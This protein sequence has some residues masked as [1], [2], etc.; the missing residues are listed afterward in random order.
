MKYTL[1]ITDATADEICA[2][3]GNKPHMGFKEMSE[4]N[5]V[6]AEQ[7]DDDGPTNDTPPELDVRG[8]PWNKRIHASSKV[9]NKDGTWRY[10]RNTSQDVIDAVEAELKAM[11]DGSDGMSHDMAHN[12]APIVPTPLEQAVPVVNH[13]IVADAPLVP[14][15]DETLVYPTTSV[16][17][18]V[19][20]AE[21]HPLDIPPHLQRT[22]AVTYEQAIRQISD[23][24]NDASHPLT[25]ERV[26]EL[27][28]KLGVSGPHELPGNQAALDSVKMMLDT[29]Q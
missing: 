1:T 6:T 18:P 12:V 21:P 19:P 8:Y 27:Y 13:D 11:P 28:I 23:A 22:A 5:G 24:L 10:R 9:I 29:M 2:L 3:L 16:Q 15:N 26:A 4:A 14:S 17:V 25:A 20:G 7:Q